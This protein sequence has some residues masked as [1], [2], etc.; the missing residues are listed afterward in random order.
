MF[1]HVNL[2]LLWVYSNSK[3][4]C[5]R[6]RLEIQATFRSLKRHV[7]YWYLHLMYHF[8]HL[9][10]SYYLDS[11]LTNWTLFF[12][13][14]RF[15]EWCFSERW[16][17][18]LDRL[19]P[20]FK[21]DEMLPYSLLKVLTGTQFMGLLQGFEN[22]DIF[23]LPLDGILAYAESLL[24]KHRSNSTK[25]RKESLSKLPCITQFKYWSDMLMLETFQ[26]EVEPRGVCAHKIIG[27]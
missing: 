8:T 15:T 4:H 22:T 21:C 26:V 20:F 14:K 27:T 5:L 7:M 18:I 1:L 9:D 12:V 23:S 17:T 2:R 3:Y 10:F 19:S 13:A 24:D 6:L 16:G 11:H 25:V